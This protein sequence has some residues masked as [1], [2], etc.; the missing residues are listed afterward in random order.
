MRVG[1]I[2]EKRFIYASQSESLLNVAKLM[3]TQ[4]VGSVIII[5]GTDGKIKPVGIIT[6]RDLVVEV[7]AANI[8][9]ATLTALDIVSSD[10]V[11]IS[12][13]EELR[14]ALNHLRYFG[15]RRA[16]VVDHEGH[17][18]GIFSIDDSLP[19]LSEEFSEI[20]KLMS[21]ELSNE[22]NQRGDSYD[23]EQD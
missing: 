3:R 21:N 19:I 20:V 8:D 1:D 18:V 23:Y 7:L 22:I 2:C 17:L 11:S 14:D 10:L 15:V 5:D 9:A 4:H 16:P 12:E 6:D 13:S